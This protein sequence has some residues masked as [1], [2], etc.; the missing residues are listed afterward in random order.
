MRGNLVVGLQLFFAVCL[1]CSGSVAGVA[2]QPSQSD[3]QVTA[4]SATTGPLFQQNETTTPI[5]HKDPDEAASEDATTALQRELAAR[6]SQRLSQSS[7]NISQGEYEQAQAVL[8]DD[9]SELLQKY[10]EVAE[11]SGV[12]TT[13]ADFEQ[14]QEKQQSLSTQVSEYQRTQ[15]AYREAKAA[16]NDTRARKLARELLRTQNTIQQN[17]SDLNQ[18][19][20]DIQTT[21]GVDTSVGQQ[22]VRTVS[23][24][25]SET[26]AQI[27]DA[28]FTD[29]HLRAEAVTQNGS[30]SD[31]I[32]MSGTLQTASGEPIESQ[33]VNITVGAQTY[34]VTTSD[35][36]S[37]TLHYRPVTQPL[38]T[39]SVP[40]RYEPTTASLYLGADSSINVSLTQSSATVR[41]HNASQNVGF[42]DPVSLRGRVTA[43]ETAVGELPL[44]V[45]L[46]GQPIAQIATERNGSFALSERLNAT[47]PTG[48]RSLTITTPYT[49]RS[50][51]VS[52][53][54]ASVQIVGRTPTLTATTRPQ[55]NTS[56]VVSG[57]LT[58][59]DGTPL[60]NTTVTVSADDHRLTE[61]STG[62][63]GTYELALQ[64]DSLPENA[65]ALQVRYADAQSNLE[66]VT[67]VAS[68]P[69]RFA[70]A[71]G[72][73]LTAIQQ[74]PLI[75]VAL[76]GALLSFSGGGMYLYR[77]RQS[78]PA[79]SS[80]D[81]ASAD[82][83]TPDA[84][85]GDTDTTSEQAPPTLESA[86]RALADGH[87]DDAVVLAYTAVRPQVATQYPIDTQLTHWQF[88]NAA[89]AAGIAEGSALESLTTAYERARYAADPV[90]LDTAEEVLTTAEGLQ[91]SL[92]QDD[93]SDPDT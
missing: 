3:T 35:T 38:G 33:R 59:P 18:S 63:N 60:A 26:Q 9:Y 91:H 4:V 29:T 88:Y 6:L 90:G 65:S 47:I 39:H 19:Y 64:S 69:S 48:E 87:P 14:A 82:E 74:Q 23:E 70:P 73:I 16:G 68:L 15:E 43:N 55:G 17:A 46:G 44:V 71:N 89:V 11:D 58:G 13:A 67:T 79:P 31:P 30:F 5:R 49:N 7:V 54:T 75:T 85:P 10:S 50:V 41:I 28:E 24:N 83:E 34:P 84:T 61:T 53:T 81:V 66:A 27:R 77:Q 36:G 86:E 93:V 62:P 92:E 12:E 20:T 25:I 8:G 72:G 76:V 32:R 21:L 52:E 22:E 37:F 56:V 57:Q 42:N 40:V 1:I 80:S 51:A 2:G 45:S 78:A